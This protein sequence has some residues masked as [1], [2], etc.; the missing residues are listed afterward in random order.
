MDTHSERNGTDDKANSSDFADVRAAKLQL[1]SRDWVQASFDVLDDFDSMLVCS[2]DKHK[3]CRQ[4]HG[5]QRRND[6]QEEELLVSSSLQRI[7]YYDENF[8]SDRTF[9]GEDRQR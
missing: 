1:L 4:N 7:G 8:E 6:R 9:Y 5:D 3:D 2:R